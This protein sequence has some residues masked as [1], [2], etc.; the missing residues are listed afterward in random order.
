MEKPMSLDLFLTLPTCPTCGQEPDEV[1]FNCTYN[2][3]PMWYKIYPE[4]ENFVPI[5]GLTGQA[6]E[7]KIFDAL[8]ILEDH[9][10]EFE[11]L[12]PI[13]RWGSY[14]YLVK[15]LTD[16]HQACVKYPDLVWQADR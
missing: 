11:K 6:A 4:D 8:A 15:F 2:L 14:D 1:Y 10:E 7:R 3:A 16:V 12:N 5:E 9:Q 13:N